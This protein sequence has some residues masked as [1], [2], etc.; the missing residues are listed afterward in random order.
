M[1][2][3]L[4]LRSMLDMDS[5]PPGRAALLPR[6]LVGALLGPALLFAVTYA[7]G[8]ALGTLGGAL[9]GL[10]ALLPAHFVLVPAAWSWQP[11][12]PHGYGRRCARLVAVQVAVLPLTLALLWGAEA[13]WP[14]LPDP[15]GL[16]VLALEPTV[17]GGAAMLL[18]RPAT[19][20]PT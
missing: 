5:P 12:D 3:A 16:W 6:L 17:A 14:G 15:V 7:T 2:S 9:A 8:A 1:R 18:A 13:L 4:D 20:S 19:R 11:D 10:L